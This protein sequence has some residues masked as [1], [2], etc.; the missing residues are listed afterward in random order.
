VVRAFMTVTAPR[1]RRR[2]Q[3]DATARLCGRWEKTYVLLLARDPES[4]RP[5]DGEH[6]SCQLGPQGERARIPCLRRDLRARLESLSCTSCAAG[7]SRAR[8]AGAFPSGAHQ[9]PWRRERVAR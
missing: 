2:L 8:I 1:L 3:V 6:Q 4:K 7:D 5:S 9:L